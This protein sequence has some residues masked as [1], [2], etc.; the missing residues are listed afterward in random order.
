MRVVGRRVAVCET[1]E[2][3]SILVAI[4]S[5]GELC[6]WCDHMREEDEDDDNEQ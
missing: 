6:L 5:R 4:E 3:D 2:Q 1:C